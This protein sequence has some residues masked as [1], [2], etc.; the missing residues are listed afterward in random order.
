MV[1]GARTYSMESDVKMYAV[2]IDIEHAYDKLTGKS[3]SSDCLM[4]YVQL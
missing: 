3:F 2:L 1:Y 4:V